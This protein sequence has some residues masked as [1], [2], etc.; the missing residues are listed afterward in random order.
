MITLGDVLFRTKKSKLESGGL[1]NMAK[2]ADFL[3]QNQQ[4]KVSIEGHTDSIGT[5]GLNQELSEWR[6][7]RPCN[8]L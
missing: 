4:Y 1:R 3:K 6:A 7:E 5:Q 8:W 2:L